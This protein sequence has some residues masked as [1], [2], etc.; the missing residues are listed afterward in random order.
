M[1][2]QTLIIAP[3][4]ITLSVRRFALCEL[5]N[6]GIPK[7]RNIDDRRR[8][9]AIPRS[10]PPATSTTLVRSAKIEP[11]S[12]GTIEEISFEFEHRHV[13]MPPERGGVRTLI[14]MGAR[15]KFIQTSTCSRS[16]YGATP[17]S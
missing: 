8:L 5:E 2:R 4:I 9:R 12:W 15:D 17:T 3:S 6:H 7:N 13:S 1:A 10:E 16:V 11:L 14:V